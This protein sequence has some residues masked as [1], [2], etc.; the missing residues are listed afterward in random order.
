[1]A[2][3]RQTRSGRS[4]LEFAKDFDDALVV[5]IK[6]SSPPLEQLI[7]AALDREP[8]INDNLET[9]TPPPIPNA[10]EPASESLPSP[11]LSLKRPA[12]G[13]NYHRHAKR[14]RVREAKYEREG[15]LHGRNVGSI[16][17]GSVQPTSTNVSDL[18][19]ANGGYIGR[20]LT[21]TEAVHD[22]AW[23]RSQSDWQYVEWDGS[24]A[25]VLV[26]EAEHIFLAGLK[27]IVDP[28]VK[29]DMKKVAMTLEDTRTKRL[30]I[31]PGDESHLR[32]EGFVAAATGWSMGQG[33]QRVT[34]TA[35]KHEAA[36]QVLIQQPCIKRLASIQDGGPVLTRTRIHWIDK[37]FVAGFACWSFRNYAYYKSSM[38]QLKATIP[39]FKP[40][41]ER[42]MFACITCNFGP[43]VCTSCHTDAK[44]CPHSM[45]AITAVGVFDPTQGGH[46][47]LRDLKIILEFPPGCTILLP[48][49]ILRH[50]NTPVQEG[51]TRYS[52]TQYSAGGIFRYQEY[53]NRTSEQ[54][55]RQDKV[56]YD[57]LMGERGKRWKK[58]TDMFVTLDEVRRFHDI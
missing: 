22:V 13:H 21:R 12:K 56:L 31:K 39:E 58:M 43:Q 52:V 30:I 57:K 7:Q 51:E 45:C 1:M 8:P 48:S 41:F 40:N 27:N 37:P 4:Y 38:E 46:L 9:F 5:K 6:P 29:E 20:D 23:Y 15:H 55:R 18:P 32:G 24:H 53:G 17:S 42:S 35:G 19:A 47:V 33:Q 44:N 34:H 36:M 54:L 50:E 16:N 49:A 25:L 3:T 10:G 28:S 2:S 14:Q 26:D 11:P